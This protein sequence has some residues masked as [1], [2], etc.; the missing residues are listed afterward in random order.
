MYLLNESYDEHSLV[1]APNMYKPQVLN[2]IGQKQLT[3]NNTPSIVMAGKEKNKNKRFLSYG[4]LQAYAGKDSPGAAT[5][6]ADVAEKPLIKSNQY[7]S[8][9]CKEKRFQTTFNY[10]SGDL[11]GFY[12]KK[13][14][15]YRADD[16]ENPG[17][18]R[19]DFKELFKDKAPSKISQRKEYTP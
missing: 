7:G 10:G 14:L 3:I 1:P 12:S 5:Y 9:L 18:P 8:A 4:H 15:D 2:I 19:I 16:G 6:N 13:N 11:L 17:K